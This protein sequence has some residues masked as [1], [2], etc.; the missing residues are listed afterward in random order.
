V[1]AGRTEKSE[2]RAR[3]RK[4]NKVARRGRRM[5]W[6]GKK[7]I[8]RLERSPEGR[9]SWKMVAGRGHSGPV[10][11]GLNNPPFR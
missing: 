10:W 1:N 2:G 9:V 5:A 6:L 3:K 7:S 11:M 4:D 8:E